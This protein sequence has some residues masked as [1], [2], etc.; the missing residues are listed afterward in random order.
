MNELLSLFSDYQG[1]RKA[2]FRALIVFC[3]TFVLPR[4]R[5]PF[6]KLL[7]SID[8]VP[9]SW[10]HASTLAEIESI[11]LTKTFELIL[12]KHSYRLLVSDF[13]RDYRS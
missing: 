7:S 6:R 8:T 4:H 12:H 1:E 13:L 2:E 11:N 3:L 5:P 9:R 10:A